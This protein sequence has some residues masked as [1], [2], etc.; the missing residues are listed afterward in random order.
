[1]FPQEILDKIDNGNSYL[2]NLVQEYKDAL[3]K[4]CNDV[5]N[6]MECLKNTM[7]SLNWRKNLSGVVY[8]DIDEKNID[9]MLKIIGDYSNKIPP[10]VNAG[11]DRTVNTSDAPV[12]FTAT[13]T[14]GSGTLVS[15][16]WEQISGT[17]AVISGQNTTT[18]SVNSF[19]V[20][21]MIFKVTVTD[22]NN[23]T[24]SDTVK[25]TGVQSTELF[26]YFGGLDDK[27]ILNESQITSGSFTTFY[28]MASVK[29]PY[30]IP[31][32]KF[33]W[34]AIP[35]GQPIKN[36]F[37][38]TVR[39]DNNGP[40]GTENDFYDAPVA[41]GIFDFY[42]TNYDTSYSYPSNPNAGLEFSTI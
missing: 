37:Q 31:D 15:I 13:V 28:N 18:L 25:L 8:N 16:L 6:A 40:I 12:V 35:T 41:S 30:N 42:I 33:L 27:T 17:T 2:S 20:G 7:N 34:F 22:S 21:E 39:L 38:D 11:A 23:L 1:M 4:G 24:A 10:S 26:A 14:L 9:I 5:P 36:W 32:Y 19:S 29:I 3:G